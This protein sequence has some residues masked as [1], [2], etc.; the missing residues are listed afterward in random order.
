MFFSLGG[1][2]LP[3]HSV[4]F[5]MFEY[6]VEDE[7]VKDSLRLRQVLLGI[8]GVSVTVIT[9]DP[10]ER[11]AKLVGHFMECWDCYRFLVDPST[12]VRRR[13]SQECLH[14]TQTLLLRDYL[15]LPLRLLDVT[16]WS[17]TVSLSAQPLVMC[18]LQAWL[19][20]LRSQVHNSVT[21]WSRNYAAAIEAI[22]GDNWPGNLTHVIADSI[23]H[24][25]SLALKGKSNRMWRQQVVRYLHS[26]IE[27]YVICFSLALRPIFE[28]F[29]SLLEWQPLL[30]VAFPQCPSDS[31]YDWLAHKY[32]SRTQMSSLLSVAQPYNL[33]CL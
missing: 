2:L 21:A 9:L 23:V 4:D 27:R 24:I 14:L 32:V 13:A 8:P 15:P 1:A 25:W 16:V 17:T 31:F 12:R 28:A 18:I 33:F 6:V 30:P 29:K 22:H 10:T 20:G 3:E 11:A 5:F 19:T 7:M 26:H